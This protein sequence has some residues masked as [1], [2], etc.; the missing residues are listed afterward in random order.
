MLPSQQEFAAYMAQKSPS[1]WGPLLKT[2][3]TLAAGVGGA[4]ITAGLG[5]GL[6]LGTLGGAA[7]G[8]ALPLATTALTRSPVTGRVTGPV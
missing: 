4:G 2:T 3:G 8:T 5:A 6:G 7:A 1:I